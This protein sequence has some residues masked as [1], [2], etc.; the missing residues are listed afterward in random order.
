MNGARCPLCQDRGRYP[1]NQVL[2][3]MV[4]CPR[5]KRPPTKSADIARPR[6]P[7]TAAPTHRCGICGTVGV[8][9]PVVGC[10]RCGWDEMQPLESGD[11][12]RAPARVDRLIATQE[13][14]T[15][16]KPEHGGRPRWTPSK[17][18]HGA[19]LVGVGDAPPPPFVLLD[20]DDDDPDAPRRRRHDDIDPIKRAR[21]EGRA[22]GWAIGVLMTAAAVA[23]R[24]YGTLLP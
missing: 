4:D 22:Q 2:G 6:A 16:H 3:V 11:I 12:V 20:E 23:W 19:R 15:L 1:S 7:H 10:T 14:A 21:W 13:R 9:D 8:P 5:C 17:P 24:T 18:P